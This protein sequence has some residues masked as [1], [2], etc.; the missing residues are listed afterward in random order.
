M[1]SPEPATARILLVDDDPSVAEV[2]ARLLRRAGYDVVTAGSGQDAVHLLDERFDGLVLDLRLPGMRG[3][4]FF[5]HASAKQPWLSARTLFVTGDISEQAE[6]LV[7]ATGCQ[8]LLKPFQ[9]QALLGAISALVPL[10][11]PSAR[12]PRVG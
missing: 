4:A 7:A 12:I 2:L 10:P 9:V 11:T 1:R 6:E 5:Y 3:D 8:L